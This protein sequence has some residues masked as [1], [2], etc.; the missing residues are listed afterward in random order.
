MRVIWTITSILVLSLLLNCCG[1]NGY[2]PGGDTCRKLLKECGLNSGVIVYVGCGKGKETAELARQE[3]FVVQGLD[4]DWRYIEDAVNRIEPGDMGG[5]LTFRQWTGKRLPYTDNMVNVIFWDDA[6]TEPERAEIMRILVPGG[7]AF[8]R[9]ANSWKQIVKDWPEEIDEWPH[10]RYDAG[11]TGTSRDARVGPVNHIQW[12][13]GP[14]YM[15][16]HEIE[17]GLSS[18][19]SANG[20]IY[21]IID[22]GPLGIT[23]VRFPVKW[24]LVCRDAFNGILLWKRP[25]THWGWK[26]WK[27]ERE[28]IPKSWHAT[29]Q[30]VPDIDRLML[31]AGDTLFVTLGFGYPVS[32]IDGKTGTILSTY[33]ETDGTCELICLEGVLIVRHEPGTI[34][35]IRIKDGKSLWKWKITGILPRSLCAANGKVFF[36]T[37]EELVSLD[38]QTGTENWRSETGMLPVALIVSEDAL[39]AAG[40]S[41]TLALSPGTGKELWRG[42]GTGSRAFN[43]DMFV[44]DSL[45]W[46]G[47]RKFIARSIVDGRLVKKLEQ[48]NT[49]QSG[50]HRRCYTDRATCNYIITGQRGSE[51]MDLNAGEHRRHNWFRGTCVTG[52]VPANG[53]F[54][55]PPNQCFCYPAIKMDGFFALCSQLEPHEAG[56]GPEEKLMKG[57]AFGRRAAGPG[58]S[59][60]E[61]HTYRGNG[62]RSGSTP[63]EV[64]ATLD[65]LWSKSLDG[66]LTQ[67]VIADG[68][69]F[70]AGKDAGMLHCMD[71]EKGRL[72]WTR[73]VP[74]RID[75]PPSFFGGS[76]ILGAHDG[77]VYSFDVRNGEL[78]WR[79]RAAP[80]ERQIVSRGRLGSVWPVHGS[81]LVMDS[82]VYCSSGRSGFIDGGLYIY[83]LDAVSGKQV[84]R[85]HLEGPVPGI[86]R[87]SNAFHQEGYRSDLMTTDGIYIYMGRTVFNRKLEVVE[88]EIIHMVGN[89]RGDLLEYRKM[90]GMRLV[91]TGGFL[92]ET[93]WNRTWW[94]YSRVWPGFHYAQQAPKSGQMLVFDDL[95]TYT[96]KFYTTRNR[97]SPMFFPGNGY[98]LFA[99]ENDNEPLFYRGTGEPRPMEWEPELP[100]TTGWSI[101]QD[102]ARDKGPG[103]TRSE[104]ALWTSW[105]DIRIEAMVLAGEHLIIA[106]TPDV[107]PEGDPLA[108]LEGRMGGILKILEAKE[109][110]Q[111]AEYALES[112]PVFDGLSVAHG[113]L[114]IASQNGEVLCLGKK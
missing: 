109:G 61:W 49:L 86:D 90:P 104:P 43:P 40:S 77:W 69:V 23:D 68:K 81:V 62:K 95:R 87:P 114:V 105:V 83:A 37:G 24:S 44:S 72:L 99:D 59:P 102:A 64:P 3:N 34:T 41:M 16:S 93:F 108:A 111:V 25:L 91:V 45:V 2:G 80:E 54:Y 4:D 8:I 57:P 30:R 85:V 55:V 100:S 28:N 98:L 107:V 76:V 5:R 27:K 21:Y 89:Q 70:V 113:K 92:D 60:E 38:L 78:K 103:F 19:V 53:L 14:R 58:Y 63:S 97:H 26:A 42:P 29:R 75:S 88:P 1:R 79:F 96:V 71:L 84:H 47:Y 35:A 15:R 65:R 33:E 6:V 51:F 17:S 56:Q 112:K 11:N 31:A 36:H 32:V 67:A 48:Q 66:N 50:H 52:M 110:R 13:A 74:G 73:T 20:R 22:E 12:E 18:L 101:Y 39:L 9:E 94:M 82:L 46:W 7:T 10:Y 106:G